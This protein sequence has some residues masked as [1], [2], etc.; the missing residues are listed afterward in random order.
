MCPRKFATRPSRA[1]CGDSTAGPARPQLSEA[2]RSDLGR[3]REGTRHGSQLDSRRS[4]RARISIRR[5]IAARRSEAQPKNSL[6]LFL[7]AKAEVR[8]GLSAA[9][10]AQED[11]ARCAKMR[12]VVFHS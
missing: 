6:S 3:S 8:E 1:Q 10:A 11:G 12:V 4:A 5:G 2:R 7:W 9:A